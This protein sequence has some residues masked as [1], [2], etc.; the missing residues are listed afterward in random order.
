[1]VGAWSEVV[2]ALDREQRHG[3]ALLEA[4]CARCHATGRTGRSPLSEAPPFRTFGEKLYDT[5]FEQR[6]QDGL[7]TI[8][9]GMPT[10]RF[11]REDA[12]AAVN[13]LKAIQQRKKPK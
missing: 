13:Y 4:Q 6:L 9:P 12:E 11:G 5:D 10:F 3:K 1:M 7:T 8:H 2:Y